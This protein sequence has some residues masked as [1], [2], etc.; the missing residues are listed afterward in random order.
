ME[1]DWSLVY[2]ELAVSHDEEHDDELK[3]MTKRVSSSSVATTESEDSVSQK[4]DQML[5]DATLEEI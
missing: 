1:V 5:M 3:H 4:L 2:P